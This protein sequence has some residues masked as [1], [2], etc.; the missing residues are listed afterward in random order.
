MNDEKC[1]KLKDLVQRLNE[2]GWAI[3]SAGV[4]ELS[5]VIDRWLSFSRLVE[6]IRQFGRAAEELTKRMDSLAAEFER[7][8]DEYADSC[9]RSSD[10]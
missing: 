6:D 1:N 9:R 10:D 5:A 4:D 7:F 2:E 8:K 3:E